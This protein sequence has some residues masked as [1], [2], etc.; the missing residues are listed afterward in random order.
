[1]AS[2]GEQIFHQPELRA[3][4]A[5]GDTRNLLGSSEQIKGKPADSLDPRRSK[6]REDDRGGEGQGGQD[7]KQQP[8]R[9]TS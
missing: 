5:T 9:E 4:A 3:R 7:S 1:M 8:A 2:E 6:N